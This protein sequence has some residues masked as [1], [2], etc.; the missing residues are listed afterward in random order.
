MTEAHTGV[1]ENGGIVPDGKGDWPNGTPVWFAIEDDS[2]PPPAEPYDR[3]KELAILR[4]SIEEMKAGVGG[5]PFE[6]A[7][8]RIRREHNLPP[9]PRH[10]F[11]IETS[12]TFGDVVEFVHPNYSGQGRVI[13]ISLCDDLT[14]RYLVDRLVEGC[15]ELYEVEPQDMKLVVTADTTDVT[16]AFR[17]ARQS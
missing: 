9:A 6:E 5:I 15:A 1:F 7:M 14:I 16:P 2:P 3:E 13:Q 4:E 12:F 11:M 10:R 17:T 8:E